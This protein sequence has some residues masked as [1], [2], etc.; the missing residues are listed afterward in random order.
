MWLPLKRCDHKSNLTPNSLYLNP[1]LICLNLNKQVCWPII[2][3]YFEKS[4][5]KWRQNWTVTVKHKT[6]CVHTPVSHTTVTQPNLLIVC[7]KNQLQRCIYLPNNLYRYTTQYLLA[8]FKFYDENCSLVV[9]LLL[10]NKQ[11]GVYFS[12]FYHFY[13]S[14]KTCN[15]WEIEKG[16][17]Q[18]GGVKALLKKRAETEYFTETYSLHKHTHTSDIF[19][20]CKL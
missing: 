12:C 15:K 7:F 11:T 18:S 4:E 19:I 13:P 17:L 1:N 9:N 8:F 10:I 20:S 14:I 2:T 5:K 16:I 3:K 6:T